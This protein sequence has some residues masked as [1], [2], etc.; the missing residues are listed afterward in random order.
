MRVYE[1]MNFEIHLNIIIPTEGNI[2][3][4]E[5]K[6]VFDE[7]EKRM[8][9]ADED[10]LNRA[11]QFMHLPPII[12]DAALWRLREYRDRRFSIKGATNGSIELFAIVAATTYFVLQKTI[13]ES[14]TEGYKKSDCHKLLTEFIRSQID[15]KMR[16]IHERLEKSR[17]FRKVTLDREKRRI[18]IHVKPQ[19]EHG[20][21]PSIGEFLSKIEKEVN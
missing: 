10:E 7:I 21:I 17:F 12:R 5:I 18:V 13:G 3:S 4:K 16:G 1:I 15:E 11:A 9:F 6:N 14:F 19:N 8:L 2:A 20:K